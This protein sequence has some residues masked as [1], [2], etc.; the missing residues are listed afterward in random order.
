MESM[1]FCTQSTAAVKD[2][3][4]QNLFLQEPSKGSGPALELLTGGL[5]TVE[6]L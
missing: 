2:I 3:R 1:A 6:E 4:L 5:A